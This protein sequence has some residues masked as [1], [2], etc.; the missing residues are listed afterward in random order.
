MIIEM[1]I[2]T[3]QQIILDLFIKNKE[4]KSICESLKIANAE[5]DRVFHRLIDENL[6]IQQNIREQEILI[7]QR[8]E[9]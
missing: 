3:L 1:P 7:R 9:R 8:T 5:K 2:D 6:N 4:L